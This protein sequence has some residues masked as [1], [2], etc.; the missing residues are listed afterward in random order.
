MA[1]LGVVYV[2]DDDPSMLELMEVSLRGAGLTVKTYASA[3]A[4]LADRA[5]FPSQQSKNHA[6]DDWESG[7]CLL[8]DLEMPGT[9]GI[10]L[11]E[12][13]RKDQVAAC[14]GRVP[15]PVIVI[16]GR[17]S[18]KEA[19]KSMKLG[20]VDLF[21]KPFKTED[22]VALVRETLDKHRQ[23]LRVAREREAARERV[24]K[25]SPRE[26]ELLDAIVQGQ[27]TKMIAV[28]L[29]I[30]ARTVDHHRANL[31]QKMKADNVADLVRIAMEADY[32]SV[33]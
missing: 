7:R 26:R 11:L 28:S 14:E 4:L 16:T 27:S 6:S 13:I 19:V 3:E 12:K 9:S 24:S 8:L 20:A 2:V 21:E 23:A 30:S 31:M 1:E 33:S 32:R 5:F 29:G 17:A 18:V 25:L 15:C 10:E 22:L